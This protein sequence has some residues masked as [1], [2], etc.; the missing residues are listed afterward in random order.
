MDLVD[1]QI[2][3]TTQA[4]LGLTVSCARCHDH[5]FDPVPQRDYYALAGIFR[6]TETCYGTV[7][8]IQ[9]NHPSPLVPLPRDAG[10]PAGLTPLSPAR[11]DALT[12]QIA[13][14]RAE[15]A[16]LTGADAFLSGRA[17]GM[18][19]Q[20][21]NLQSQLDLY[22]ADGTPKA[23]AMGVRERRRA[24]D[25]PLFGRGEI[26]KPGEV[27]P[28]GIPQV[29]TKTQPRLTGSGRKELADWLASRDNPLTARVYVNRVWHHLFGQGLVP[30]PDNFGASGRR[31]SNQALLDHLAV[32]FMDHG[33]S[34]RKLIRHL[35]TSRAYQ[36]ATTFDARSHEADPDNALLWRMTPRRLEAEKLRDAMLAISGLLNLVPPAGSD[37]TRFG[38]GGVL[39]AARFRGPGAPENTRRTVYLTVL[40]EQLPEALT[41][42]DFPDPNAVAGER[43]TTT[44]PAQALYLLNNP[45][46][47]RQAEAA[48]DRLR[49]SAGTDADRVK[50]AYQTFFARPP[51][52][53]EEQAATEFLAGYGKRSTTRAAWTAFAQ[54]LFASAEFANRS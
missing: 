53:G 33:W 22:D 10:L 30:T 24:A 52:E 4:F 44:V 32:W 11:R 2:D 25:M 31:P 40:R 50:R 8:S 43:A 19:L 12:K 7:R 20:I 21:S 35:M 5:K 9:S 42:F 49:A 47:I 15:L 41:L 28:R 36:L 6:S 13:D 18:R 37:L 16:K 14:L 46:V 26:D 51:S 48:G 23:Q 54:A 17:I 38:E 1:E 45:F 29:L 27:V 3:T 39:F 34:T